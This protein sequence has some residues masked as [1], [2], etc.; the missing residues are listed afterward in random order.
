MFR[1][2]LAL[3]MKRNYRLLYV[4]LCNEMKMW[5][6]FP[7]RMEGIH[8]CCIELRTSGTEHSNAQRES[9]CSCSPVGT[10]A[11]RQV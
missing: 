11:D 3:C 5:F 4:C 8:I 10:E 9:F 2:K 6:F 7:L 1:L